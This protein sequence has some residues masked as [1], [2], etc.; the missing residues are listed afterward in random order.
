MNQHTKRWAMRR[1]E[2]QITI[3]NGP[4]CPACGCDSF[5]D[6]WHDKSCRSGHSLLVDIYA[7]LK[8]HG[9]G[10]KFEVTRYHGGETHSTIRVKH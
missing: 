5:D 9:C 8:C 1:D 4:K 10:S 2:L 7:D 6:W 3:A